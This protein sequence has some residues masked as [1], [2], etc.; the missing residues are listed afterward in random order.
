M[1]KDMG[2]YSSKVVKSNTLGANLVKIE[3]VLLPIWMVNVK[4]NNEYYMFAMNGQTGEFIGNIP[5]D[6]KKVILYSILI[7]LIGFILVI[8]IGYFI[9]INGGGS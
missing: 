4:Y 3:Y 9:F 8:G 1:L 2:N 7:F 6:K 5:L